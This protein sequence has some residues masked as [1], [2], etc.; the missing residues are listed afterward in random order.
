MSYLPAFL[1]VQ[2]LGV[3]PALH[4]PLM[5][6]TNAISGMTAVGAMFLLPATAA[7][8]RGAA[9]ILGEGSGIELD[10]ALIAP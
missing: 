5:S 4:S 10:D 9:Q 7:V 3:P 2:V 8:P 6:A 1:R